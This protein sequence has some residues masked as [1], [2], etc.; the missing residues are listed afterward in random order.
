MQ[1]KTIQS[2]AKQ[3]KTMQSKAMQ[4]NHNRF[5]SREYVCAGCTSQHIV[6]SMKKIGCPYY[7]ESGYCSWGS[8]PQ[9]VLCHKFIRNECT[10][11]SRCKH[12]HVEDT[13]GSR[14]NA[15]AGSASSSRSSNHGN[16]TVSSTDTASSWRA[17]QTSANIASSRETRSRSGT[18]YRD[19]NTSRRPTPPL[20][21]RPTS[22]AHGADA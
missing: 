5:G 14:S 3:C 21:R 8:Y 22:S 12:I 15:C 2:H 7:D 20:R 18:R 11:D 17:R 9:C 1:S 19:S 6:N 4:S 10:R 13:T 16:T